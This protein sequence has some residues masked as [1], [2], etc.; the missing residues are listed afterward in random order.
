M[1]AIT[2]AEP[3]WRRVAR[4]DNG[5]G[6]CLECDNGARLLLVLLAYPIRKVSKRAI[7]DVTVC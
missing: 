2:L 5:K 7:K 4:A 6:H 1:Y 3:S